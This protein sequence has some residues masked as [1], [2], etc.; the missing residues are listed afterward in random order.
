VPTQEHFGFGQLREIR[1]GFEVQIET[2]AALTKLQREGCFSH[3]TW[4]QQPYRRVSGEQ[5]WEFA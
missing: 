4:P 1:R 5:F 3:L 2:R